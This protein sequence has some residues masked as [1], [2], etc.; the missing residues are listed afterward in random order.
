V[1]HLDAEAFDAARIEGEFVVAQV[2]DA[3]KPSASSTVRPSVVR[4]ARFPERKSTPERVRA[5]PAESPP[6]S[7]K[8]SVPGTC[9]ASLGVTAAPPRRAPRRGGTV[10]AIVMRLNALIETSSQLSATYSCSVRMPPTWSYTSSEM[11]SSWMNT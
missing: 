1:L 7:R 3:A 4:R 11:P 5:A 6:M 9:V 2:D 10:P 8:F